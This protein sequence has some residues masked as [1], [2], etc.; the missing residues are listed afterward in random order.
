MQGRTRLQLGQELER[1]WT[2]VLPWSSNSCQC[3][4]V[5]PLKEGAAASVQMKKFNWACI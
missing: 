4:G 2:H 5:S 1:N 3:D